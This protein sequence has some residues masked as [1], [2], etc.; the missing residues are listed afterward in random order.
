MLFDSAE[1]DLTPRYTNST[2]VELFL[3]SSAPDEWQNLTLYSY[4]LRCSLIK[5]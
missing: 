3:A 1:N 4:R 5:H 2:D